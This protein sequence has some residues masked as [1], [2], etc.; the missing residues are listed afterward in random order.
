[1]LIFSTDADNPNFVFVPCCAKFDFDS[2][3]KV[4][5]AILDNDYVFSLA[6]YNVSIRCMLREDPKN[7]YVAGGKHIKTLSFFVSP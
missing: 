7:N 2:N 1:M 3:S 5:A 4:S 6:I